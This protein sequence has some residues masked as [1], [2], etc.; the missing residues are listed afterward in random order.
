MSLLAENLSRSCEQ[1]VAD[2][3]VAP[4][5]PVAPCPLTVRQSS[6]ALGNLA[7]VP[8]MS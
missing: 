5:A 1:S 2:S 7:S 4:H 3:G 8:L 6:K